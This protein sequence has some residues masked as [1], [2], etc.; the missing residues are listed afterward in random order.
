MSKTKFYSYGE[1]EQN[2]RYGVI[3][4]MQIGVGKIYIYIFFLLDIFVQG[5]NGTLSAI[6]L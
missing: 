5:L 1:Y 4:S 2:K 6:V 3:K